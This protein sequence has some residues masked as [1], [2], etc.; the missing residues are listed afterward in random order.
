VR[1]VN[2]QGGFLHSVQEAF[3]GWR[4]WAAPL[5]LFVFLV[6]V[7][8]YNFLLFHTLAELFAIMVAIIVAVVAWHTY[9]FSRNHYLM[10]LGAGYFWIGLLD[11]LH[12]FTFK[13]IQIFPTATANTGIQFWIVA[14][15]FEA[16]LLLIAPFFLTYRINKVGAITFFSSGAVLAVI[17]I[18]SG[19]FPVSYIDGTGLT[20]FKIVSEYVI[21]AMLLLSVVILSYKRTLIERRIFALIVLSVMLTVA[22]ELCF[23]LYISVYGTAIVAGHLFKLMSFWLIFLAVVKTTLSEPFEIMARTSGSYDAVPMPT[24]VVN[25]QGSIQQVNRAAC[26]STDANPEHLLEHDVHELFHSHSIDKDN[27]V[28]CEHIRTGKALHEYEVLNHDNRWLEYTLSPFS[29]K[30]DSELVVHVSNNISDRKHAESALMRQASYDKLTNLPNRVLAT[31]RLQQAIR[32]AKRAK[33]FAA[34]MFI[35]IDNFKAINDTLG[36]AVG[37]K[38]LTEISKILGQPVRSEDTVAR[39]GGD[40]FL[41]ILDDLYD[42]FDA[43]HIAEKMLHSLAHPIRVDEREFRVTASI[44][45][46][47]YPTDGE[48]VDELLSNADAAMYR[49]KDSGKNTYRFY[50]SDISRQASE[51]L[52][53]EEQL[54]QAIDK[55]E[56]FLTYQPQID[57]RS[58]KVVGVEALIRWNNEKLGMI[59]PVRFIPIAEETG[60][61][62]DIG[63]WILYMACRDLAAWNSGDYPDLRMSINISSRQLKHSGFL[64]TLNDTVERHGVDPTHI[65]LEMTESILLEGSP[66]IRGLLSEIRDLGMGLSLDDFGTGYSSLSYLKKFPFTQIKIDHQ[67]VRDV[68]RDTNDVALCRAMIAM[69]DSLNLSVVAEGVETV[70]QLDFLRDNGVEIMQGYYYSKPLP[71]PEFRQFLANH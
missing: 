65:E 29:E 19:H 56:L 49:A 35:D 53:M 50:T 41:V 6:L 61:I 38:L 40:E 58:T 45:I 21:I 43:G 4:G 52:V 46:A 62:Y 15:F 13:G 39:W 12:A 18:F 44:G 54:R 5:L 69:A 36:H 20:M 17:I 16:L 48:G 10:L 47:G 25:R 60:L 2:D 9:G 1:L 23:T 67:F 24:V 3:A 57:V 32:H 22:A 66:E 27:C 51:R 14:R 59:S 71:E 42:P 64:R 33:R 31:D 30:G 63:E 55:E 28:V 70:E 26:Q 7:S 34:V 68:P 8:E 11:L 37:D